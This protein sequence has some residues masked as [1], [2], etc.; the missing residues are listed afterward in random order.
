MTTGATLNILLILERGE[1][2]SGIDIVSRDPSLS[3]NSIYV[4]LKRLTDAGLVSGSKLRYP[5]PGV[6]GP[7]VRHFKITALGKASLKQSR[8]RALEMARRMGVAS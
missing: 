6:P 4:H 5:T 2:L 3:T 7:G 8:H 1:Q